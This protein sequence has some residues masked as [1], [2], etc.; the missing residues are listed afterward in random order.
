MNHLKRTLCAAVIG[1]TLIAELVS[2]FTAY[3]AGDDAA[4]PPTESN[5]ATPPPDQTEPTVAS[6]ET[7]TPVPPTEM[8]FEPVETE[9][10]PMPESNETDSAAVASTEPAAE[11]EMPALLEILQ[12]LPEDTSVIVLNENGEPEPLASQTAAEIIAEGDP[13]WCPAGAVP[14]DLGCSASFTS[15]LALVENFVPAG[16]GTIWIQSGADSS[17]SAITIDG[18]GNWSSAA[19]YA[20]TLQGGWDG[21]SGG[22]ITTT[23]SFFNVPISILNWNNTVT[24]K[25]ITVQD[26]SLPAYSGLSALNIIG[27][28]TIVNSN[29]SKNYVGADIR[30]NGSISVTNSIFRENVWDGLQ[31]FTNNGTVN[32]IALENSDFSYNFRGY[33]DGYGV[34]LVTDWNDVVTVD[35]NTFINNFAG[36][37]AYS[38]FVTISPKNTF[39]LNCWDIS[40]NSVFQPGNYCGAPLPPPPPVPVPSFSIFRPDSEFSLECGGGQVSYTI[41]LPNGDLGE[42]ICPVSG[43]AKISRVDNTTLPAPLPE[44]YTYASAINVRI[45]RKGIPIAVI[46]EGGYVR[47]SFVAPTLQPG[48]DFSILYWDNWKIQDGRWVQSDGGNWVPLKDFIRD[49]N[50]ARSFYL[51]P[52]STTVM[53]RKIIRGVQLVQG[54]REERVEVFVNFP[55]I[56][57]L[58]QH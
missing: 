3:A 21:N 26:T 35:N 4:S 55:G 10:T 40:T 46:N 49:G 5:E 17:G 16:H 37:V 13:V 45:S 20:L 19:N 43:I 15:L 58:A 12:S 28:V 24:I 1:M 9:P 11:P 56:F 51:D 32:N 38:N 31:I 47:T 29:F 53:K 39:N 33:N 50:G 25:N 48:N 14:G 22:T 23:N 42:I 52:K 44:G 41:N 34:W 8:P 18:S 7:S 6:V 57:V 27:S 30:A 2:P 36:L 54:F